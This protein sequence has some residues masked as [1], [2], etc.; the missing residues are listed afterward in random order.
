MQRHTWPR[1]LSA[2]LALALGLS[3]FAGSTAHAASN[4]SAD[5]ESGDLTGWSTSSNAGA[6]TGAAR[7]GTYGYNVAAAAANAYLNWDTTALDQDKEY[8]SISAFV[9]VNSAGTGESVDLITLRHNQSANHFDVFVKDDHSAGVGTLCWDLLGASDWGCWATPYTFGTWVLI[10]AKVFFGG[11]TYTADVRINGAA[12][13]QI[14]TVGQTATTARGFW[15]GAATAKTHDQDYDDV[16]LVLGDTDPGW[17]GPAAPTP[18][19]QCPDLV[20]KGSVD[21]NGDLTEYRF[22]WGQTV[23]MFN[24]SA[25]TSA[26]SGTTPVAVEYRV[27]PG[28]TTTYFR[29]ETRNIFGQVNGLTYV[30]TCGN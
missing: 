8:A 20:L 30:P 15:L 4:L 1:G 21:P 3:V 25:W 12:Q 28:G 5:A 26:G 9:R 19:T 6:T 27:A 2:A 23:S 13:T 16:L 10:Q 22:K 11:T 24:S 29:I 7:N 18:Q 17:V 14:D